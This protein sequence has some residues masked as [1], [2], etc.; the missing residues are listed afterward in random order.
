MWYCSE[1]ILLQ[2]DKNIDAKVEICTPKSPWAKF[3][4]ASYLLLLSVKEGFYSYKKGINLS[5]S[6]KKKAFIM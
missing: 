4:D 1:V 2:L 5:H 3:A 6:R